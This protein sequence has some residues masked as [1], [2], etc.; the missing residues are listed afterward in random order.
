M[1]VSDREG[2]VWCSFE[3]KVHQRELGELEFG[4]MGVRPIKGSPWAFHHSGQPA[5]GVCEAFAG[6]QEGYVVD[7]S[8]LALVPGAG[9]AELE[10]AGVI[11]RVEKHGEGAA[12]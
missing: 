9:G 11:E 4:V 1:G 2:G 8:E 6:C 10:E 5:V 3:R 12:L 7:V